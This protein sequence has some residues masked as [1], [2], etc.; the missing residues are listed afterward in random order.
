MSLPTKCTE[1]K[2]ERNCL[3]FLGAEKLMIADVFYSN[4]EIPD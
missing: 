2:I 1:P 4:G 3:R